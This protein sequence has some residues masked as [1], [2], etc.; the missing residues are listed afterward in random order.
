MGARHETANQNV[1]PRRVQ[2]PP[3]KGSNVMKVLRGGNGGG[4]F[5]CT[6]T[7]HRAPRTVRGLPGWEAIAFLSTACGRGWPV[8]R[9]AGRSVG[10]S[11]RTG[12]AA[13][14][15]CL[16]VS[17]ALVQPIQLKSPFGP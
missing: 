13:Q 4:V 3:A 9:L 7:A 5:G 1:G 15:S 12:Q 10:A 14:L 17:A 16:G 11:L 2:L 6:R 8:E